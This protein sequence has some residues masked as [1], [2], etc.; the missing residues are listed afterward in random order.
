MLPDI[1]E[2]YIASAFKGAP[3]S[4]SVYWIGAVQEISAGRELVPIHFYGARYLV[5]FLS[6]VTEAG[7]HTSLAVSVN[8]FASGFM[9]HEES[10]VV[11]FWRAD[12]EVLPL[13]PQHWK[14]KDRYKMT[15]FCTTLCKAVAIHAYTFTNCLQYFYLPANED[16]ERLYEKLHKRHFSSGKSS[17]L[18]FTPILKPPPATTGFCGYERT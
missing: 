3:E 2:I 13:D 5:A 4:D 6:P 14:L 1:D 9:P 10:R 12:A 17:F 8:V 7:D 11:K 18:A 15:T 16:L